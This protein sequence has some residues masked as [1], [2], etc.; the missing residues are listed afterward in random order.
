MQ[1]GVASAGTADSFIKA[2]RVT[3]TRHAPQVTAS[4]LY[5]L[6]KKT[7]AKEKTIEMEN[8]LPEFVRWCNERCSE[9]TMFFFWYTT[10]QIELILLL[11][12]RSLRESSFPLNVDA[13]TALIS[14][15][16][17]L[18]H[19]NY[20]RGASVHVRDMASLEKI[21][22]E[23]ANEFIKENFTVKKTRRAFSSIAIDQAHEQNNAAVKG[24]GGAVRLIQNSEAL[25]RWAVAGPE[26][27]RLIAEFDKSMDAS[28]KRLR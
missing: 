11:F 22:P 10:L 4:S 26:L 24:D 28:K 20:A 5:I 23:V 17:A 27:A 19:V 15:F 3:R 7:Y 14:C 13:I 25:R 21:H 6:L 2:A 16:F 8:E 9:S 12:V 18:D 1:E